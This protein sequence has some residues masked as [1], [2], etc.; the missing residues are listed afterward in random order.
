MLFEYSYK[1]KGDKNTTATDQFHKGTVILCIQWLIQMISPS[2]ALYLKE[3]QT[4]GK[5][6]FFS[7]LFVVFSFF[8]NSGKKIWLEMRSFII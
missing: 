6:I 8:V 5:N 2:A 1:C 4:F 7:T 3:L